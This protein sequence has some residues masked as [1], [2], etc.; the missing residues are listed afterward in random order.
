MRF[1]DNAMALPSQ[2]EQFARLKEAANGQPKLAKG[3]FIEMSYYHVFVNPRDKDALNMLKQ[4]S[5]ISD[6]YRKGGTAE[7][8]RKFFLNTVKAYM[9]SH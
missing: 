4:L 6:D 5:T 8:R 9:E 1:F 2:K 3:N 7:E